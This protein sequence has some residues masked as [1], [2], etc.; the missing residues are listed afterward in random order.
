MNHGSA[1]ALLSPKELLGGGKLTG[2]AKI[3]CIS[4]PT[5]TCI[6]FSTIHCGWIFKF[7]GGR[8]MLSSVVEVPTKMAWSI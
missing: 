6:T 5:K 8:L 3:Q 7:F 4:T 1:N 2:A